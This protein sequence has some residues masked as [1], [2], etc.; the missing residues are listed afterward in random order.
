MN[1]VDY[2]KNLE[3]IKPS[4][5]DFMFCYGIIFTVALISLTFLENNFSIWKND[6][7]I[8]INTSQNI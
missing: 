3:D 8:L 1:S 4:A 6:S 5:C 7:V 2:N